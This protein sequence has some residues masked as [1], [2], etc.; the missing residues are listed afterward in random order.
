MRF[1]VQK[2][3]QKFAAYASV[4]TTSFALAL[5]FGTVAQGANDTSTSTINAQLCVGG[6]NAPSGSITAPA[7]GSVVGEAGQELTITTSWVNS[8]EV[9]RGST[10]IASNNSVAYAQNV[11]TN[12]HVTL[13]EGDNTLRLVLHGGCPA[14]SV[15]AADTT[16][17]YSPDS[18]TIKPIETRQRSPRLSG[19][20]SRPDATIQITIAGKTYTA[21]NNGDG[22]WTLPA[23]IISPDL[24]DG[25]YDVQIVALIEGSI[26]SDIITQDAVTIDTVAPTGG[27][28]TNESDSRS[29]EMG[30]T[31]DDPQATVTVTI[32]GQTYLAQNN[33]DGTWT[34]PAGVINS[35]ASGTYDVVLTITDRAGNVSRYTYQITIKAENELGFLLSPNTG[36]LRI[37]KLNIPSWVLYAI[38]AMLIIVA[39][40][41]GSQKLQE[42]KATPAELS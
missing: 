38:A 24:E 4:V 39:A 2:N 20:V 3:V 6:V 28:A 33:G 8:Y 5:S 15:N 27:L 36:Y 1:A 23:G 32:N 37:S 40:F 34:L 25:S 13:V 35:L 26:V 30:G 42:R 10:I 7:S 14:S 12:I 18:A 31:V 17:T 11:T 19:F 21:K 9:Y 29:P 41:R 16:L 22:T